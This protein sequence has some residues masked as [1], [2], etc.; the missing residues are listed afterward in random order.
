MSWE[1]HLL[2]RWQLTR[3]G[4]SQSVGSRQQRVIAA[5]ALLGPR[6]RTYIAGLLWPESSE[7]QAA[8]SLRVAVF[9][10]RHQL[11]GLLAETTDPLS[12]AENVNVDLDRLRDAVDS[13][14]TGAEPAPG[15]TDLLYSAELL[16][17]WYDDWLLFEQERLRQLRIAALE[18]MARRHLGENRPEAAVAAAMSAAAIEPLRESA[19]ALVIRG[20]MSAGNGAG[21]RRTYEDFRRRLAEEMGIEPSTRLERLVTDEQ[22]GNGRTLAASGPAAVTTMYRQPQ[23]AMYRQ[24]QKES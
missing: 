2:G 5:L 24:P 10:I 9:K 16:P 3:R 8:S 7:H 18:S 4:T 12:L 21:A 14:V 19:Q 13:A 6:P 17:G 1:L 20:Q 22:L 15:L 11:P 23:Q